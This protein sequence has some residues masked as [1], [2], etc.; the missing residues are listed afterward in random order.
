MNENSQLN[1]H[2]S[3][4]S[5][6]VKNPGLK[7]SSGYGN[8]D[9]TLLR[10]VFIGTPCRDPS[11]LR[12]TIHILKQLYGVLEVRRR[13]RYKTPLWITPVPAP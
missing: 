6:A 7:I 8:N 5:I 3:D 4:D 12:V 9:E 2:V 1:V 11:T 13:G 10:S